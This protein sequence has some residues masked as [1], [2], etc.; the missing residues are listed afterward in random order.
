MSLVINHNLMAQNATRNLSTAYGALA[1]STRRLSSGLRISTAADDAAGLAVRELMR[2]DI[3]ALN[4]G[5]R[6]ANDA[7]SLIQTADGALGVIDEKLIRMKELAEQAATGTY[8]SDQ[9]IIIDSEYQAMASEITRIAN[10][11]DFNGIYLLNGNLSSSTHDGTSMASTGKLK[12]HFGTANDSAEDYYYIQIG[13]CTASALG[14]G[15]GGQTTSQYIS[16]NNLTST[17][18]TQQ[19]SNWSVIPASVMSQFDTSQNVTVYVNASGTTQYLFPVDRNGN[20]HIIQLDAGG[21]YIS[22]SSMTSS[23]SST[24]SISTQQLAQQ[25]LIT[26][27]NAII[28]KDKIRANLGA[29]QNRL[30]NT[31]SNLQIQAENLQAAESRISD[32]DV[33]TE[34]TEF[35]RQQILTQAAVAMLSQANSLPRMALQLMG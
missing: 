9:R 19:L 13:T 12:V 3:A 11:T 21:G 2:A 24:S 17:G 20:T 33:A 1:T 6:N 27:K 22:E 29:L 28:S 34:M 32:V 10:A 30:E 35:V 15:G 31:I 26:V 16:N 18:I 8:T 25:A 23:D 4:Q 7:I 14:F 5:V